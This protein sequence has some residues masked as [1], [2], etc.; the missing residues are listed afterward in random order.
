MT[1]AFLKVKTSPPSSPSSFK[2]RQETLKNLGVL[3]RFGVACPA[4]LRGVCGKAESYVLT[5]PFKSANLQLW[6]VEMQ[7]AQV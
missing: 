7:R 4:E 3:G 6:R 5:A 1:I 2:E